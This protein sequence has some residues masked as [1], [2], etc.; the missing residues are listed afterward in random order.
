MCAPEV[1]AWQKIPKN[2]LSEISSGDEFEFLDPCW[3]ELSTHAFQ[4]YITAIHESF[5]E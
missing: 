5:N 3:L 1:L 2:T 4:V